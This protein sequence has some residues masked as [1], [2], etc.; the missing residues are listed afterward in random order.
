[1]LWPA[2]STVCVLLTLQVG[3]KATMQL[4]LADWQRL[5]LFAGHDPAH[6]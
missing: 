5:I 4:L 2:P 6:V 3:N 1:M